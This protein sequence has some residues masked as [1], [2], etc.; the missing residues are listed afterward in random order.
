MLTLR[1]IHHFDD[2]K[3]RFGNE[4]LPLGSCAMAAVGQV[5]RRSRN[6]E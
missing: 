4:G 3:L 1:Q 6:D 5:L 2:A